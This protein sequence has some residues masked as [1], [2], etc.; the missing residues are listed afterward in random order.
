[1]RRAGRILLGIVVALVLVL[2]Q[3]TF[4]AGLVPDCGDN[5]NPCQFCHVVKLI[6]NV[7]AWLV[8]VLSM[9]AAGLFAWAGMRIV[10]DQ[11]NTSAR[12][13][14]KNVFYNVAIGFLIILAGW[15][16][17]DT[18]MKAFLTDQ[19]YGVWNTVQCVEQPVARIV[20]PEGYENRSRGT[21]YNS[22]GGGAVTPAQLSALANL[23]APDDKVAAAAAAAGL[24]AEQTRNLQALMRVESGG[25]RDMTSAAG[26]IGCMQVT[27][28][29]ARAYDSNLRGL[30][31]SD[32]RDRLMN[33]DYNINLGTKI[34]ADLYRQYNGDTDRVFAAYNGGTGANAPS[35]DCPGLMRWQC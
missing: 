10:M 13:W 11:G 19:A 5:G 24:D 23:N 2:P 25:C 21:A 29:T 9:V 1:M 22:L 7:I 3:A 4:A 26:A 8:V 32:V 28:A 20:Q 12:G 34:Y 33:N 14:A 27:P 17:V 16:I 15:L 31:D 18:V 30:S 35:R 6:N